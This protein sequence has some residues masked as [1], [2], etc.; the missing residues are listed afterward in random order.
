[1]RVKI[2]PTVVIVITHSICAASSR[3]SCFV[4]AR[5]LRTIDS[6]GESTLDASCAWAHTNAQPKSREKLLWRLFCGMIS[7]SAL[8]SFDIMFIQH[9][10]VC[11][12][13]ACGLPTVTRGPTPLSKLN[14]NQWQR[15]QTENKHVL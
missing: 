13:N 2:I 1:M 8:T 7:L 10:G 3:T 6:L 12:V 4:Y 11:T 15:A 14:G 9:H 5:V